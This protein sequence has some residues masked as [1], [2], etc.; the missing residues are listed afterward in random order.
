ME[1]THFDRR[2]TANGPGIAAGAEPPEP[3]PALIP[4][5]CWCGGDLVLDVH[6]GAAPI[7]GRDGYTKHDVALAQRALDGFLGAHTPCGLDHGDLPV[8]CWRYRCRNAPVGQRPDGCGRR[9]VRLV[10]ARMQLLRRFGEAA[11][12]LW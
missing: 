3:Y 11:V 5:A 2:R 10:G 9:F 12:R 8:T 4:A 6:R 7:A 1:T